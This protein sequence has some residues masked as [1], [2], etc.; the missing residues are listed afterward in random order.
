[1]KPMKLLRLAGFLLLLIAGVMACQ[2]NPQETTNTIKRGNATIAADES[3]KPVVEAQ[4]QSYKAHYPETTFDVVYV[5]E[6]RAINLMLQDSVEVIFIT[7]ELQGKELQFFEQNKIKYE[8]APM[9][10]DAVTLIVNK[11]SDYNDI[12]LAELKNIFENKKSGKK[13][14]FDNSNSSNLNFMRSK[15]GIEDMEDANIFAADGNAEVFSYIARNKNAIGVV[16]NNWISD[17]DNRK[18]DTL[19]SVVKVLKVAVD[20]NSDA[21]K[22]STANLNARKY[23]LERLIYLHTTKSKWGV[24]KGLIRFS[25]SQT[26]QLVVEKM[27]LIPY[28]KI[29]KVYVINNKS[30]NKNKQSDSK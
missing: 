25:C 3:L 23:P 6:Q 14:V 12:T 11:N 27:G 18:A 28:Y 20:S 2:Y 16:G 24:A 19:R 13:L 21:F 22:P 29:P 7:R 1:M 8:P 30:I 10:L 17:V 4:I 15:L 26:G 5:P 9:A